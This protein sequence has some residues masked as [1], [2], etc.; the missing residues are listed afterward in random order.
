MKD[1]FLVS[2]KDLALESVKR[3]LDLISFS[4]SDVTPRNVFGVTPT[5]NISMKLAVR[6][7]SFFLLGCGS[8]YGHEEYFDE[9]LKISSLQDGRVSTTFSFE[10]VLKGV[11]PRD[12]RLLKAPD[13]C[14]F[15]SIR[16]QESAADLK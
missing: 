5:V 15:T 10:T 8:V 4:F 13:S 16:A 9:K 11:P 1:F 14:M 2:G 3:S 12:P 6:W 7:F